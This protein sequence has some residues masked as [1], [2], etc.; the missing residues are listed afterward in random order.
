MGRIR[1]E[2]LGGD[3]E[4][5]GRQ[6]QGTL[7]GSVVQQRGVHLQQL[8]PADCSARSVT[9]GSLPISIAVRSAL[10]PL[11]LDQRSQPPRGGLSQLLRRPTGIPQPRRPP[12]LRRLP[13][14][15]Q[16]SIAS[17][18]AASPSRA[19][20]GDAQEEDDMVFT[21]PDCR[22]LGPR[23]DWSS[24]MLLMEARIGDRR[25]YGGGSATPLALGR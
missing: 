9:A 18:S 19:A 3:P 15:R 14:T 5:A 13:F 23:A 8:W 10:A 25:L 1:H 22:P 20:A 21:R 12:A 4:G 16:C 11:R 2:A 7:P 24:R 17:R 6:V